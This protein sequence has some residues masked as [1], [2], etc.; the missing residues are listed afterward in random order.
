MD[1]DALYKLKR[2]DLQKLA[3][4]DGIRANQ[5]TEVIINE[6]LQKNS[7]VPYMCPIPSAFEQE[8]VPAKTIQEVGIP[9]TPQAES[10]SLR[11]SP[12]KGSTKEMQIVNASSSLVASISPRIA[13]G[14]RAGPPEDACHP[15]DQSVSSK[16]AI[17][18]LR[19]SQTRIL[20]RSTGIAE[21]NSENVTDNTGHS[22]SAVFSLP[23]QEQTPEPNKPTSVRGRSVSTEPAWEGMTRPPL[24][25]RVLPRPMSEVRKVLA[26]LAPLTDRDE[27]VKAEAHEL[28][29]LID[30]VEER[31]ES[32]KTRMR[33][34]QKLRLALEEF[35]SRVKDDPRLF[36]GTWAP[37]EGEE[38]EAGR[39]EDVAE[40][41]ELAALRFFSFDVP[42]VGESQVAGT[43]A[44]EGKRYA[45]ILLDEESEPSVRKRLR[46]SK[47]QNHRSHTP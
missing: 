32:L 21:R 33:K 31:M 25:P 12:C 36:N 22:D 17:R 1:R 20:P 43:E 41:N 3:K 15:S 24:P 16:P 27:N 39:A 8:A 2:A 42:D 6:L 45:G 35:F 34:M 19:T 11:R 10:T 40:V 4:R 7:P 29:I 9:A 30:H 23:P 46:R 13:E 38:R 14:D 47:A 26:A 44:I 37:T 18:S 5:K 28:G